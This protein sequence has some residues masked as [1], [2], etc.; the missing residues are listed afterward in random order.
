LA[1]FGDV[2]YYS[3]D[4]SRDFVIKYSGI[5]AGGL[6]SSGM[7]FFPSLPKDYA[8]FRNNYEPKLFFDSYIYSESE[9]Q[10]YAN[11]MLHTK[12]TP[13]WIRFVPFRPYLLNYLTDAVG[14]IIRYGQFAK[15]YTKT[16]IGAEAKQNAFNSLN[17][18]AKYYGPEKWQK[19]KAILDYCHDNH[20]AI[21]L[22]SVPSINMAEQDTV[23]YHDNIYNRQ[24][25][26]L[27][28]YYGAFYVDGY[29]ILDGV[30]PA[31]YQQLHLPIDSHWNRN[32]IDRFVALLI[33]KY[34]LPHQ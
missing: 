19:L 23:H 4:L 10:H 1:V 30:K 21:W 11:R 2:N 9:M 29:D 26:S 17:D 32:G 3:S 20:K 16:D 15:R 33:K 28:N 6:N 12:T 14:F 25:R 5:D 22:L 8:D 18:I 7:N 27:A 31:D 13:R 34:Q 24:L